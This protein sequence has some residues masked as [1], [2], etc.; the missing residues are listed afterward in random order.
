MRSRDRGG[1]GGFLEHTR[2]GLRRLV[3]RGTPFLV[4]VGGAFG[5]RAAHR[6]RE[7]RKRVAQGWTILHDRGRFLRGVVAWQ[8]LS[9]AFRLASVY[10]FLKAFVIPADVENSLLV[11]VVQGLSTMLPITPGGAG[12]EQG[13]I[14]YV[15]RGEAPTAELLSFSVGMKIAIIVVNGA[16]G[17]AAI[18]VML[19]TFRWRDVVR[20]HEHEMAERP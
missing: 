19:K 3:A 14:A 4:I 1:N 2:Q 20:Q 9:W 17:F 6:V 10:Y 5:W 16:L 12:T 7:F 18:G 11:L 15:F 8:A 13:L